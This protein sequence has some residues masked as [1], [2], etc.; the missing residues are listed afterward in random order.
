MIDVVRWQLDEKK[1]ALREALAASSRPYTESL[2]LQ[3]AK[4][5]R[6]LLRQK[7]PKPFPED[8]FS[9]PVPSLLTCPCWHCSIN[10]ASLAK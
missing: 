10:L 8:R 6:V 4:G 2:Y 5:L 3:M 1:A 9:E 7:K